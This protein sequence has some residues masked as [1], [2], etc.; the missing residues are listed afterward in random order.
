M[1]YRSYT[2]PIARIASGGAPVAGQDVSIAAKKAAFAPGKRIALNIRFRNRG[3]ED[4]PIGRGDGISTLLKY[5]VHAR[6]PDGREAPMT[7]FARDCFIVGG[8]MFSMS[9]FALKPGY[10]EAHAVDFSRLFDFSLPGKYTVWVRRTVLKDGGQKA[11]AASNKVEIQ[12]D[13]KLGGPLLTGTYGPGKV[14]QYLG[15]KGEWFPDA[16]RQYGEPVAGQAISIVAERVV[17]PPSKPIVLDVRFKNV[18]KT[19]VPWAEAA[20]PLS[21]YELTVLEPR[22]GCTM[23]RRKVGEAPM[24]LFAKSYYARPPDPWRMRSTLSPGEFRQAAIDMTRLYDFSRPG[25][26]TIFV[27]RAVWKDG[28]YKAKATSNKLKIFVDDRRGNPVVENLREDHE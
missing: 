22:D 8:W 28:G 18:G 11:K 14:A 7:L 23:T 4:L 2:R 27:K 21:Q 20:N 19:D 9:T 1:G 6:L 24:S 17:Y 5:E 12:V 3:K 15:A 25:V 26:Y 16:V 13:P 10:Y